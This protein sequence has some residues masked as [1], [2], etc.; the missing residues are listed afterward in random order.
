MNSII[1]NWADFFLEII[2]IN[3]VIV[4]DVKIIGKDSSG[5]GVG[6]FRTSIDVKFAEIIIVPD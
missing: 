3:R 4:K 1:A 6:S 2:A 5:I